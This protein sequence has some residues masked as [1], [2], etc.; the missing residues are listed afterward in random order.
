MFGITRASFAELVTKLAL[1]ALARESLSPTG[2]LGAEAIAARA[3]FEAL[4]AGRLTYF[5]PVAHLPGFPRALSRTLSEVRLAGLAPADLADIPQAG[6]DLAELLVRTEG[7]SRNAGAVDRAALL[8]AATDALTADAAAIPY[9]ALVLLDVTIATGADRR[10][11]RALGVNRSIF[12]T[13]ADGDE[14]TLAALVDLGFNREPLQRL[15]VPTPTQANAGPLFASVSDDDTAL[16]RLQRHVFSNESVPE[17][18]LDESV[19]LFSAPGEG[20]EATEIARRVMEEGRRGVPFDRMA[21]LLR[22][23]H[24]YLG[25]LEHAFRRAGIPVVVRSR[26]T[27]AG[28]VRSRVSRAARVGRRGSLRAALRRVSVARPGAGRR[29]SL[30]M[31]PGS[32]PATRSPRRSCRSSTH[33]R[34]PSPRTKRPPHRTNSERD[35]VVAGTLQ[36]AVALGRVAG[37]IRGDRPA[38]SMGTPPARL[39]RGVSPASRRARVR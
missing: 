10:I 21:V 28:S 5:A 27:P 8:D 12:A 34:T 23:P 31:P 14:P 2:G 13:V 18:T 35:G 33:R 24:T 15:S 25:L 30:R 32:S 19:V 11:V 26:H 20:R 1:P 36:S 3:A 17:G 9:S 22:A 39:A 6:G 16:R 37:R 29:R 38:R 7:E 4:Q